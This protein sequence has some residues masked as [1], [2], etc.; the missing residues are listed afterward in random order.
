MAAAVDEDWKRK[1]KE[2]THD[3][4]PNYAEIYAI[5]KAERKRLLSDAATYNRYVVIPLEPVDL[6]AMST[7]CTYTIAAPGRRHQLA[8]DDDIGFHGVSFDRR[9]HVIL[10]EEVAH[11][12]CRALNAGRLL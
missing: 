9:N 1:L 4:H 8:N 6:Y 3:P 10:D 5:I 11:D 7:T 12:L 2:V